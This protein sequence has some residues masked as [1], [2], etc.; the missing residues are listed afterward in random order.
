MRITTMSHHHTVA[1][2]F[3]PTTLCLLCFK[4]CKQLHMPSPR[5]H[6]HAQ[7]TYITIFIYIY[8]HSTAACRYGCHMTCLYL[9]CIR[10]CVPPYSCSQ[11][12]LVAATPSFERLTSQ[13]GLQL[14]PRLLPCRL[15][16][17]DSI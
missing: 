4:Q 2:R 15:I 5:H 7:F 16:S 13:T 3:W 17:C 9:G 8:M 6:V 10:L 12:V 1:R 14:E 11:S